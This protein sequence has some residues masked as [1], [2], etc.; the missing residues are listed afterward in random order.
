LS[1][2][3]H[4]GRHG[5]VLIYLGAAVTLIGVVLGVVDWWEGMPVF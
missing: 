3:D 2:Q 4:L 1:G 5:R